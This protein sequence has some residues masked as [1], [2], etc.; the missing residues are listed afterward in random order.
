MKQIQNI[1]T[2]QPYLTLLPD[3]ED[4]F[5]PDSAFLAKHMLPLISIDLSAVNPE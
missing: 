4:V 5:A 2:A 1:T 3:N